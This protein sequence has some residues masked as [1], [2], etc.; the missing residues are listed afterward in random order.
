MF[1]QSEIERR[2]EI[3]T[4]FLRILELQ[5]SSYY[6]ETAY[7]DGEFYAFPQSRRVNVEMVPQKKQCPLPSTSFTFHC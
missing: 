6:P 2:G 1:R 5:L 4:R 3:L 7:G